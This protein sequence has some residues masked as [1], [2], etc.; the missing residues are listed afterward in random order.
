MKKVLHIHNPLVSHLPQSAFL[1]SVIGNKEDEYDWIM[2]NFVNIRMNRHT[3]YE[4]FYRNDMWYNCYHIID[5]SMTKEFI[6]KFICDDLEKYLIMSIDNGYYVY[7]YSVEKHIPHYYTE[8]YS[9]HCP[10]VFGYDSDEKIFYIADF[11]KDSKYS[12]ECVTFDQMKTSLAYNE[13]EFDFYSDMLFRTIKKKEGYSY[14]FSIDGLRNR[15]EE[16]LIS[17]DMYSNTY[18]QFQSNDLEQSLFYDIKNDFQFDF[19]LKCY[20]A[21][22]WCISSA[23]ISRRQFHLF[24]AHKIL[25]RHRLEYLSGRYNLDG[26]HEL[27]EK[28]DKLIDLS[29][30]CRNVF[31]KSEALHNE[32]LDK[33]TKEKLINCLQDIKNLDSEFTE[34]LI[35]SLDAQNQMQNPESTFKMRIV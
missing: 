17:K 1:L 9:R 26:I 28:C 11:F 29:L 4:D 13:K 25:M 14:K 19:G 3:V 33:V 2:S 20:D 16:Y 15:L 22:I 6:K 5:N 32:C 10:M 18:P 23:Y 24:Y 21:A 30:R 12:F 34:K 8:R 31:M 27:M 7:V 35:S